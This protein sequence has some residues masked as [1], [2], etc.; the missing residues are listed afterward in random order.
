MIGAEDS[1]IEMGEA[2]PNAAGKTVRAPLS[3]PRGITKQKRMPTQGGRKWG[4]SPSHG[5]KNDTGRR[6][7]QPGYQAPK[8]ASAGTSAPD[9]AAGIHPQ[10]L[11]VGGNVPPRD[12]AAGCHAGPACAQASPAR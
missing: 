3:H 12:G 5:G 2:R 9:G 11:S 7:R 6:K 4:G 1:D 8:D 10:D